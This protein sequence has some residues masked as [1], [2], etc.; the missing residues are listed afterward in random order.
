[1]KKRTNEIQVDEIAPRH[2]GT[3][4]VE[5]LW[6]VRVDVKAFRG[7]LAE[8]ISD[9]DSFLKNVKQKRL[10]IQAGGNC[11]M[12]ARFYGN[13]F[14][15]V[16]TFEPEPNNFKC[17]QLN[18]TGSKYHIYNVGLGKTMGTADIIHPKGKKRTN[19][20]V[21]Q[22]IE[23]PDGAV[24][25]ITIDSLN[26]PYCDLIHLDIEEFEP[27]ALEGAQQT[28]KKFRPV[29]I[30]EEGHGGEVAERFGYKLSE[31]MTRDWIYLYDK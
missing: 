8:W 6:W 4:G 18:C 11:G 5:E 17:L 29:I 7:P 25:L 14:E 20:G 3:E 2:V 13:Y 31:K 24:K 23:N 10:V 22:T 15:D 9:K 12:Y 21:W 16:Y 26:L 1:M 27:M 28:I 19:M 30:L